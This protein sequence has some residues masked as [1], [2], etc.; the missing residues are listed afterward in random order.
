MREPVVAGIATPMEPAKPTNPVELMTKLRAVDPC[1]VFFLDAAKQ[2]GP[3]VKTRLA[4]GND[5]DACTL[6]A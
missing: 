3:Q 1:S 2:Y 4:P 6:D 5:L